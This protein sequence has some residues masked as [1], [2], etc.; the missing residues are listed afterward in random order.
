MTWVKSCPETIKFEYGGRLDQGAIGCSKGGLC[1]HLKFGG[2]DWSF[3]GNFLSGFRDEGNA[4]VVDEKF[5]VLGGIG[6]VPSGRIFKTMIH[7]MKVHSIVGSEQL[8][9]PNKTVKR[10]RLVVG[11]G[12]EIP[13]LMQLLKS[14]NVELG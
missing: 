14:I 13:V 8:F 4:V 1:Y 11:A 3:V 7:T 9:L 12:A 5:W 10:S 2:V 6:T